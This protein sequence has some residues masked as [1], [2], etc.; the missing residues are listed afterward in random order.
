[1]GRHALLDFGE[2]LQ[3]IAQPIALEVVLSTHTSRG[4]GRNRER[5]PPTR[6]E[7][8]VPSDNDGDR[9]WRRCT[10]VDVGTKHGEK[11]VKVL[12]DKS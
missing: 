6:V 4:G 3:N 11:N 2:T 10:A 12:R 5:R 1:V 7:V 9:V 8:E